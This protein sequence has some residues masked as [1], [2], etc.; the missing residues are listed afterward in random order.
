MVNARFDVS[1]GKFLP[2]EEGRLTEVFQDVDG[3]AVTRE[4]VY[5]KKR[6]G[7]TISAVRDDDKQTIQIFKEKIG[8]QKTLLMTIKGYDELEAF[9]I[10]MLVDR[11]ETVNVLKL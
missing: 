2:D 4:I 10:D 9:V 8:E 6:E 5:L 1:Y 7:Y 3:K 11:F